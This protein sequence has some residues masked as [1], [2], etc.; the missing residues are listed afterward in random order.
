[1]TVRQ[2]AE[3]AA[4]DWEKFAHSETYLDTKLHPKAME[5]LVV[6]IEDAINSA[7]VEH[8]VSSLSKEQ[9]PATGS[10]KPQRKGAK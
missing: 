10:A 7:G 9:E 2:I 6:A 3:Q 1:M 4:R 5:W 8:V